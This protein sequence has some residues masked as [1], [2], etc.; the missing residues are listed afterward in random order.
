MSKDNNENSKDHSSWND[1]NIEKQND[2][3]LYV[4]EASFLEHPYFQ[5]K[6]VIDFKKPPT[7]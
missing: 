5:L 1:R 3:I 2:S 4:K 6:S 7:K